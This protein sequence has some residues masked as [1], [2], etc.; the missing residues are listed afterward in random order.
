VHAT[1]RRAAELQ[2]PTSPTLSNLLTRLQNGSRDG[3]AALFAREL[4][5]LPPERRRERLA[6]LDALLCPTGWEMMR[7]TH[8]LSRDEARQAIIDG[9]TA[10][11]TEARR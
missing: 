9:T 3:L 7:T 8:G 5:A 1:V 10:L 4:D 2:A 11:L 6:A